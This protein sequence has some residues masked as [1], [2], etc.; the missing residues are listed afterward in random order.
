MT[1]GKTLVK[2]QAASKTLL[3]VAGRAALDFLY[4][5]VCAACAAPVGDAQ[6]LCVDCWTGLRPITAPYCPRLGLPFDVDLGPGTL[7]AAALA[8]PPPFDRARSGVVYNQVATRLVSKLKYHDR[9]DLALLCARLMINAGRDVLGD[10]GV[11]VPVPLHPRRQFSRRYNQSAALAQNLGTLTG[12]PHAP[13][14]VRRKKRTQQQ[15]GLSA[16][17]RA[18]NVAGAFEV[19]PDFAARYAGKRLILVDD[20]ITTGATVNALTKSLQKAGFDQIDVISFAR[21]V[22][23]AELPI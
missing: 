17:A 13:L 14:L 18:K 12:L 5:P 9:P 19:H 2:I 22:F 23:G 15:V 6:S 4:P 16:S 3:S 10:D 20:V 21:V 1:T 11:L 8:D 7:S